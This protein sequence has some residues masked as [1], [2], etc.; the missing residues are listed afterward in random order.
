[1]R[2]DLALRSM[3]LITAFCEDIVASIWSWLVGFWVFERNV[4]LEPMDIIPCLWVAE[5]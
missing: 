1:M 4:F 5:R 2:E 3:F